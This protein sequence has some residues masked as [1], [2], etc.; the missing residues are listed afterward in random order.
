[1]IGLELHEAASMGDFETMEELLA[2]GKYDVNQKDPEWG[3]RTPLHWAATK[4]SV[5][6]H[7]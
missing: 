4:G 3:N 1:M 7:A 6:Y 2:S 5:V